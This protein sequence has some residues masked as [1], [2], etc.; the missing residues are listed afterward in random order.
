MNC[1]DNPRIFGVPAGT[2]LTYESFMECIHPDDREYINTKWMAGVAGEPYDVEHRIIADDKV[3]WVREKAELF[4]NDSGEVVRA[5]GVTQDI[6]YCKQAENDLQKAKE[7][8]EAANIAKSQFLANMSHEIRTPMSVI[9]GFANLLAMEELTDEQKTQAV[10]IQKAGK[11]LLRIIDDVLDFSRIEAGKLEVRIGEYTLKKLLDRVESMMQPLTVKKGLDFKLSCSKRLPAMIH[12]DDDRL[13]QCLVNLIGNAIKFTDKGS[14]HLKVSLEKRRKKSFVRFDAK[15]TG[16]GIPPDK[17]ASIFTSFTQ[18]DGSHTRKQGGTGL[19]L[20]ITKE[21]AELLGGDL[22]FT[23]EVGA[24]SVFSLVIPAA[25]DTSILPRAADRSEESVSESQPVDNLTFRGRILVAE[26]EEGSHILADRI[27][28]RLGLEVVIAADGK[29][30]IEKAL[31]ESWDLIFMD[32]QMPGMNGYEVVRKLRHEGITT[33]II[34][35]TAYA[36]PSDRKKCLR[37]G[38][39]GYISKPFESKDVQKVLSSHISIADS[40]T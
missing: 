23:S 33:P 11:S 25:A 28:T 21:L 38:C 6:S 29:E 7:Q 16:M 37:A 36:M 15:D 19:G 32:I 4:F 22:S 27:L 20:T 34:A 17:H 8:A 18:V 35:L 31:R 12:T 1:S 10:L 26:D 30:A 13:V 5:I 39:D 24:G 2:A 9:M 3:K 14:I 40:Q